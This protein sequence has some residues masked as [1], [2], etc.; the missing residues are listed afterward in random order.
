[1]NK[2]FR[3]YFWV[4]LFF[5]INFISLFSEIPLNM[6]PVSAKVILDETSVHYSVNPNIKNVMTCNSCV[7]AFVMDLTSAMKTSQC[8]LYESLGLFPF[9]V[10]VENE[11]DE[12]IKLSPDIFEYNLGL[13]LDKVKSSI[14][15][16]FEL[17]KNGIYVAIAFYR[18]LIFATILSAGIYFPYGAV[19][20]GVNSLGTYFWENLYFDDILATFKAIPLFLKFLTSSLVAFLALNNLNPSN[21]AKVSNWFVD[22]YSSVKSDWASHYSQVNEFNQAIDFVIKASET[23]DFNIE[24]K[25]KKQ[26]IIFVKRE[27]AVNIQNG[28]TIP[29]LKFE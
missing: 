7:K 4:F 18:L 1:M 16:K 10:T 19:A 15:K 2:L 17:K 23:V 25:T 20:S 5:S 13:S 3:N 8:R 11:S 21:L 14:I 22:K 9:M 12:L 24:P 6:E 26:F 28:F 27:D 29:I